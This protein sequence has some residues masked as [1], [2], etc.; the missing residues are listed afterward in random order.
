MC[1][2]P[3]ETAEARTEAQIVQTQVH[4]LCA[5]R[6]PHCSAGCRTLQVFSGN[7]WEKEGREGWREGEREEPVT[8]LHEFFQAE[9]LLGH[10]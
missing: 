4:G 6:S 9:R 8:E 2:G 1:E 3:T 5:C 10:L 7:N